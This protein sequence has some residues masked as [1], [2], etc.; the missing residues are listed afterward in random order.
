MASGDGASE[1]ES[2]VSGGSPSEGGNADT[3]GRRKGDPIVESVWLGHRYPRH[4]GRPRY[5]TLLMLAAFI[6]LLIL[7]LNLH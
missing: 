4:L 2:E 6:G 3:D 5:T 7:Y 1:D